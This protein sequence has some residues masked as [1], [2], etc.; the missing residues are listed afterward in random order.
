MNIHGVPPAADGVYKKPFIKDERYVKAKGGKKRLAKNQTNRGYYL[1]GF[2]QVR[3]YEGQLSYSVWQCN[4]GT[5]FEQAMAFLDYKIAV[6]KLEV[7][8]FEKFGRLPS[9]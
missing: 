9:R 1:V 4:G 6:M 2:P 8:F 3:S 5:T 7:E